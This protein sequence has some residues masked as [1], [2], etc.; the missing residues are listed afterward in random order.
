MNY[1]LEVAAGTR[2]IRIGTASTGPGYAIA[3]GRSEFV[4]WAE[5]GFTVN[6][7]AGDVVLR[8]WGFTG[9]SRPL[10]RCG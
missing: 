3:S 4:G 8:P 2:E 9:A 5:I 1:E 10:D 6:D 7:P